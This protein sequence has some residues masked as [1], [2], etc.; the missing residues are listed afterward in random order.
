MPADIDIYERY[1]GGVTSNCCEILL[2]L[3]KK[4]VEIIRLNAIYLQAI[5]L[6]VVLSKCLD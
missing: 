5:S 3:S 2:G 6:C 1:G 4:E